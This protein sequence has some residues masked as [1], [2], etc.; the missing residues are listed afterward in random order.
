MKLNASYYASRS[1]HGQTVAREYLKFFEF[2]GVTLD[3]ALRQFLSFF[4][5]TGTCVA[6]HVD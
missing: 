2:E 5:L 3:K 1:E 6:L 4:S